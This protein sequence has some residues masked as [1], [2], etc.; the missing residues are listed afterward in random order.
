MA[1][2]DENDPIMGKHFDAAGIVDDNPNTQ[3]QE[4]QQGTDN[5]PNQEQ[6]QQKQSNPQGD[7]QQPSTEQKTDAGKQPSTGQQDKS[8]DKTDGKSQQGQ[9]PQGQETLNPGDLRLQ[10]GTIVKAGAERRW[11]QDAQF[12]KQENIVLKNQLNTANQQLQN[13]QNRVNQFTEA[14]KAVGVEDPTQMQAAIRLYRDLQTKPVEAI[15][16]LLAELKAAGY[17][18]DGIGGAVDTAAIATI[19]DRRLPASENGQQGPT[20]EEIAAET[21]REVNDL[22]SNFPDARLHEAELAIVVQQNPSIPLIDCYRSLRDRAI[23]AGFD[24]SQP[25]GPQIAARNQQQGQQQQQQQT[26][27][28]NPAPI[29][30]RA[31]VGEFSQEHDP[32][33]IASQSDSFEDA[34]RAS[35]R[36]QGL[37]V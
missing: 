20:E 4:N 36:E 12:T 24:W 19:I 14:A 21:A 6:T 10:D 26:Q 31:A 33:K 8:G 2:F 29:G 32:N 22:F 30:G 5:A 3:P 34:I 23:A 11:Y 18:I 27:N 7:A 13:A 28:N 15:T 35:M 16:T 25:L 1:G 9:K 17:K 37:K